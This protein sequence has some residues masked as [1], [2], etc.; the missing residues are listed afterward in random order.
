M[1]FMA[2]ETHSWGK[3]A[4]GAYSE[5]RVAQS[6]VFGPL[7]G[8]PAALV[9]SGV[10]VPPILRVLP[11]ASVV[12]V[13]AC[14]PAAEDAPKKGP[15]P[16]VVEVGVTE[17]PPLVVEWELLGDVRA[18][19]AAVIAAGAA[20]EL[21]RV[22][23]REG[24]RVGAGEPLFEV[25]PGLASASLEA[26]RA[27]E[28]ATR[29]EAEQAARDAKR[30]E[31]VDSFAEVESERATTTAEILER[32]RREREATARVASK[33]LKLHRARAPFAGQ[34]GARYVGEGAWVNPG[35]QVVELIG[36]APPEVIVPA[37]AALLD[38]V[39]VGT[40]VRL[41]EGDREVTGRLEGIV[42]ALDRASRAATLRAVAD[43]H[44][45]FLL[46]GKTIDAVF[47]IVHR[48]GVV[49]PRD[50]LVVGAIGAR[51]VKVVDGKAVLVP[52]TVVGRTPTHVLVE[53][54]GIAPGE[55][56]VTR[57]NER[58]TPN[59]ELELTGETE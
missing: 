42:R 4:A 21:V 37:P 12:W 22:R 19:D 15:P 34:I 54:E 31:G 25:D 20:G 24:D 36:D 39:E 51:V 17:A 40:K 3:V 57:G 53:G 56:V 9:L 14:G 43:E 2:G 44:A 27:A 11:F 33:S 8:H 13:A 48:E 47:E 55:T 16:A 45:P 18:R 46:P 1:R 59:Q 49:I 58:L 6:A 41:R 52:V 7:R 23:V 32:L 30:L 28:R 26:A 35:D 29:L 50:A 38:H 5:R 10:T